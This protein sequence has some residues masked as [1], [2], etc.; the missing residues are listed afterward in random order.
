MGFKALPNV[1]ALYQ[2]ASHP[3]GRSAKGG[4]ED[5]AIVI[6]ESDSENIENILRASLSLKRRLLLS[7]RAYDGRIE[8][9]VRLSMAI[10]QSLLQYR[11]AN[12]NVVENHQ[13]LGTPIQ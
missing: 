11:S 9:I 13:V 8:E 6:D 1:G 7:R 10:R 3:R 4:N 12:R 5:S 2:P